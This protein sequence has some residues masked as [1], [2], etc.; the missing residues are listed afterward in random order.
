AQLRTLGFDLSKFHEGAWN[1]KRVFVVGA[2]DGDTTTKQFWI[3][4]DDLVFVRSIGSTPRGRTEVR[5]DHNERA[6]GGLVGN[7]VLQLVNGR[8][9]LREQYANVQV[10][11]A[12]DDSYFDPK[13]WPA[14][15]VGFFAK[16]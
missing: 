15:P 13:T 7:E 3:D 12:L 16:P 5:F 4:H 14:V 11:L 9:T 8:P 1:G 2:T 10:D 6:K